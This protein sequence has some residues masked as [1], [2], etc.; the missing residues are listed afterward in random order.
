MYS[1]E[2]TNLAHNLNGKETHNL[3]IELSFP[4]VAE[5]LR[6]EIH[7]ISSNRAHTEKH[8]E[9]HWFRRGRQALSNEFFCGTA[10]G[11]GWGFDKEKNWPFSIGQSFNI[12]MQKRERRAALR[13]FRNHLESQWC[14]GDF[15]SMLSVHRYAPTYSVLAPWWRITRSRL[16]PTAPASSRPHA[17]WPGWAISVYE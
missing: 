3:K 7:V 10:I 12:G 8:T 11:G 4:H 2:K 9:C 17:S 13:K 16:P 15:C 1:S 6:S 14:L 5:L